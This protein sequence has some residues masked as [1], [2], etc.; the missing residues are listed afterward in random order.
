MYTRGVVVKGP[1]PF[2]TA[3]SRPYVAL[4]DDTHP[5]ADEE[6]IYAVITSTARLEAIPITD[7]DFQSGGL[8]VDPS[9]ASPWA[10]ITFKH[11]DIL[12]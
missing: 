1:N 9:Y 3:T 11:D 4:S 10:L 5:F 12:D 7:E 2:S 6:A 8:P